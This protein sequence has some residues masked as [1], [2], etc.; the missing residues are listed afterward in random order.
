[1]VISSVRRQQVDLP[2]PRLSVTEHR[3][4]TRRCPHCGLTARAEF[5]ADVRVPVPYGPRL[6]ARAASFNLYQLLPIA[7][8][9]EALSDLFGCPVSPATVERAGRFSSGKLV[10]SEQRLKAA[11]RDSRVVGA[12]ETGLRVAGGTGWVHVARTDGLTHFAYDTRRGREAINEVGLLP[13]FTG[14]LV[15][16]GYHSYASF[17]QCRHSLGNAHLLREL[18]FVEETDPAQAAWTRPLAAL[19]I[20][21]KEAAEAARAAGVAQLSEGVKSAYLR[22]YD[23]LVKQADRRNPPPAEETGGRDSPPEKRRPPSPARRL[24]N[25]LSRRRDEMLRFMHDL[26]VWFDNNGAE[27]DL[28]MVKLQQKISGC[29]RT[30]DGARNFCRVRSYL[31]TAR[32]QGHSLLYSLER[33]LAGKP[34][35][36]QIAELASAT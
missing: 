5:P 21:I 22:R 20:E 26:M 7:R 13:Q 32:K 24:I 6:L 18:V 33:V 12:D 35:P 31:S 9:A 29:F 1:V 2:P 11:I 36:F 28:R 14:T 19:L 4:E 27:R 3:R 34:L 30:S 16:D 23:R 25:R 10:G 17:G 8:T 15:R